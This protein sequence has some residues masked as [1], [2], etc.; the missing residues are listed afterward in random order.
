VV[1]QPG[2]LP[3]AINLIEAGA[4]GALWRGGSLL[5]RRSSPTPRLAAP[6]SPCRHLPSKC[7]AITAAQ[8]RHADGGA[9]AQ[10]VYIHQLPKTAPRLAQ[11]IEG[12]FGLVARDRQVLSAG[13][14]AEGK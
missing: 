11:V 6:S 3:D 5:T 1:S 4:A 14:R 8:L 13:R 12:V 10:R 2:R 7:S 9:L